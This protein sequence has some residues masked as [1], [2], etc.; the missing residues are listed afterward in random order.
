MTFRLPSARRIRELLH[1]N[2]RTGVFTWRVRT[3]NRIAVGDVAGLVSDQGYRLIGVDGVRYRAHRLAW[4][5]VTGR[6]PVEDIDH[7]DGNRDNNRWKNLREGDRSFNL[8]NQ[9]RARSN[10]RTGF[11][12]VR[13]QR[14][15]ERFIAYI[16]VRGVGHYLGCFLDPEAAHIVY[17]MAKRQLHEGNTL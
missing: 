3:S 9:R 11:L 17:L 16:K 6:D 7:R 15:I 2:R 1:Y 10:S 4:K 13:Y 8:E 5:Y 14:S 12:G